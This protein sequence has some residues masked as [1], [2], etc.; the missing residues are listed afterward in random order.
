MAA[1]LV[2]VGA[3]ALK[4]LAKPLSSRFQDF[5]MQ[6]P[7]ARDQAVKAAQAR[8]GGCQAARHLA[9]GQLLG[10]RAGACGRGRGMAPQCCCTH[11]RTARTHGTHGTHAQAV[12]R[13]EV[14]ITRGA[15]G[16]TSR[17][18]VGA[19]SEE[20]ALDLASKLAGE[21]FV[22]TVG[23]GC[24]RC[25]LGRRR[26]HSFCHPSAAHPPRAHA[27]RR[28]LGCAVRRWARSSLCLSTS[29]ARRRTRRRSCRRRRSGARS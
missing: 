10:T 29:A 19:L 13:M 21:G 25:S 11:A 22:F 14:W 15:E 18:F 16:R 17:A 4:T 24:R 6:H 3:L 1:I 26:C 2:K 5:V 28:A 23:G 27:R 9:H 20:K 12:H 7:V 8:A